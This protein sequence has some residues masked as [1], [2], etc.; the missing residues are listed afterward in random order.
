MHANCFTTYRFA[1]GLLEQQ[2][3]GLSDAQLRAPIA[4]GHH[5]GL[6]V[7]GHLVIAANIGLK[8]LGAPHSLPD[9]RMAAFGPGSAPDA[10]VPPGVSKE[11]L[12]AELLATPDL[13]EAAARSAGEAYLDEPHGAPWLAGTPLKTRRDSIGQ[14]FSYHVGYHIGQLSVYRRAAG[15]PALF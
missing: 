6:W 1:L 12:L 11:S 4:P 2:V 13:L 7:L 3:D 5:T 9:D 10:P 15:L 8:R 14:L